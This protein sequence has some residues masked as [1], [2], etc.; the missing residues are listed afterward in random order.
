MLF[1]PS[2]YH[3]RREKLKNEIQTGV[4]I[5]IGNRELPM[6]YAANTFPFRQD[7]TFLYFFGHAIPNIAAIIDFDENKEILFGDNFEIDDIIWMGQQPSMQQL[8]T[9][10]MIKETL[11]FDQIDNY[12]K[13]RN[14]HFIF[15]YQAE[16]QI[17]L[18]QILNLPIEQLK[19]R[20]SIQLIKAIVQLRSVKEEIEIEQIENAC[21]IGVKM[22]LA[23][24]QSCH[25]GI[26]E[27]YLAGMAEGISL[28]YGNGVS[29]PIILSQH[30]ETLHNHCHD[31]ILQAG[32]LLL[33]DAGATNL[34]HYTSD[35]TRTIPVD[36][37][38][39]TR[40]QELYE[41][42][43]RAN[44]EAIKASKPGVFY[45]D[46]HL[47]AAQIVATGLKEL[48]LMKGDIKEAVQE[49]AHALFFPHGLGHQLGLDVHDME[50]LGENY[51]GYDD[52]ITRS[53]TFGL[54]ALR[55]ARELKT[56]FIITVEPGIYFIPELID[57]W[58]IERKFEQFLNYEKIESYKDAGGIRI[59]DD[60]L[61][62]ENG[63]R[64][65]GPALPK[66]VEEVT[67]TVKKGL[68]L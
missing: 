14:I 10:V 61:I 55:M 58:K 67:E 9:E 8:A 65:L 7:S 41:I 21:D 51:V 24:M 53:T 19:T 64:I 45:R 36:G 52:T 32:K 47:L 34:Y 26:S 68:R 16:N 62:T 3:S 11:P 1:E 2:V 20:A 12:L 50:N 27:R 6:N 43:L 28:S 46:I 63:C 18:S 22:H 42:V 66:T 59:E 40:H 48:G 15:P 17:F 44:T 60:I 57:I 31:G 13:G 56:G 23:V 33:M 25:A 5:F 29:F 38:F 30:G 54:A 4:A 35:Y 49:G 37:N 39:T